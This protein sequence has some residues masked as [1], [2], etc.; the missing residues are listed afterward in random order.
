[1]P[2]KSRGLLIA[3]FVSIAAV[4]SY[5]AYRG[6]PELEPTGERAEAET[7]EWLRIVREQ[8]KAGYWIVV[9]GTHPGDQVVAAASNARLTHA[10]VLDADRQEVIE[11]VGPGVRVMPLRALLAESVRF[12]LVE[13]RGYSPE[14]GAAALARARSHVGA[15][16]DWFGTVGVQNDSSY[17]C[18]EL[19]AD[20]Y[21]AREEG[22]MPR[23]VLHPERLAEFGRV[24]HDS[25][26]R[27]SRYPELP[28]VDAL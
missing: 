10:A 16:Y 14:R 3:F 18:S 28:H 26:M 20:A 23:I 17:Y 19:C 21:N 25:G 8:G 13:P 24:V 7:A 1:M 27:R 6:H 11:A 5:F 9:R 12:Q 4:G 15:P 2:P 22:W